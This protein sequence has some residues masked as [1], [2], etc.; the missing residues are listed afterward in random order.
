M[1]RSFASPDG[2]DGFNIEVIDAVCANT[3]L[4]EQ[5][6]RLFSATCILN[7]LSAEPEAWWD[8]VHSATDE[9]LLN[10]AKA[11]TEDSRIIRV[12]AKNCRREVHQVVKRK[13]KQA[14]YACMPHY[15]SCPQ[16]F[17]NLPKDGPALT[18]VSAL[19]C[20][21]CTNFA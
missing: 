19:G 4:R 9:D 14:P 16:F 21:R 8:A 5:G 11:T 3:E 2:I 18:L 1:E 15:C 17:K 12:V 10:K 20:S 13:A 7:T 6:K